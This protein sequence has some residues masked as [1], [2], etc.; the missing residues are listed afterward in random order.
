[1]RPYKQYNPNGIVNRLLAAH[2]QRHHSGPQPQQPG[3]SEFPTA[4]SD[5]TFNQRALRHLLG[6]TVDYHKHTMRFDW[7]MPSVGIWCS[8]SS[9]QGGYMEGIGKKPLYPVL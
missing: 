3:S 4:G 7:F 9:F 6:G 8:Y 2:Q 1:M 5:V